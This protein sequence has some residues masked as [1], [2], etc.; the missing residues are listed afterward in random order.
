MCQF[1]TLSVS[2][3]K[4]RLPKHCYLNL[5]DDDDDEK[6]LLDLINFKIMGAM[7]LT[8]SMAARLSG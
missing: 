8:M 4:D 3:V 6:T 2:M 7:P 1:S 5:S